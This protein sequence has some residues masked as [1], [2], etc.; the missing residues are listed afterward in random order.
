[1]WILSVALTGEPLAA[2]AA[3]G[4]LPGSLPAEARPGRPPQ[5][6][7]L[8]SEVLQREAVDEWVDAAVHAQQG[9][10]HSV[11]HVH[12]G[13]RG[14]AENRR[15]SE[16][17]GDQ[18]HVVGGHA[19]HENQQ[20]AQDNGPGQPP[21]WPSEGGPG[22]S[23]GCEC[24]EDGE[25]AAQDR[26]EGGQEE[27]AGQ[28]GVGPVLREHLK[29]RDDPA[30][31]LE[32]LI[33]GEGGDGAAEP[34]GPDA[35][36]GPASPSLGHQEQLA[37]TRGDCEESVDADE[38]HEGDGAVGGQVVE[39]PGQPAAQL[40]EDPV[41]AVEVVVDPQGQHQVEGHVRHAQVDQVD[42]HGSVH[43][44]PSAA[45]HQQ[46]RQVARQPQEEHGGIDQREE[47]ELRGVAHLTGPPARLRR[48]DGAQFHESAVVH[49]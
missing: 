1:M 39:R 34:E 12:Q 21:V 30:V 2:G 37:P 36:A 6:S 32:G 7:E 11:H 43:A 22:G 42:L 17:P 28:E 31:R 3:R 48:H 35:E 25:V 9:R 45:E 16:H 19:D 40:R 38:G 18:R 15:L 49:F 8:G 23:W 26:E 4:C 41:A 14:A 33:R 46:R 47:Q 10:A 44:R 29:A 5:P 20:H 24:A 13:W 27:E